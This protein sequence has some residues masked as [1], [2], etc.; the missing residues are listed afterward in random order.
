MLFHRQTE[1]RLDNSI[2]Q[3]ILRYLVLAVK[4]A[5]AVA[6]VVKTS[7]REIADKK[8][9]QQQFTNKIKIALESKGHFHQDN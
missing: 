1:L 3:Q 7:T 2:H 8:K 6:G 5:K 4:E 9:Q